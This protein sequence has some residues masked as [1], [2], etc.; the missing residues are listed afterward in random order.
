MRPP[1]ALLSS[2]TVLLG[3]QFAGACNLDNVGDPP[4]DADI[5]FPTGLFLSGQSEDSAA[6]FLYVLNSNFDLRYNRGSVQVFD[7][8]ALDARLGECASP[9]LNCQVP[10]TDLVVDEVLV[11][12]LGTA[13]SVSP[14]RRRLYLTSRTDQSLLYIDLDEN[15]DGEAVLQ[16]DESERRCSDDRR[17][18]ADT[19]ENARGALFPAEP[20]S[21]VTFP[22]ATAAPSLDAEN[23]PGDF[24]LVAHRW[25]QVSLFHDSGTGG[26]KLLQVLAQLPL[27]PTGIEFDPGTHLAYMSLYARTA[28]NGSS[29]LLSRLALNVEV[30][31]SG[32]LDASYL[33]DVGT[34]VIDGVAPQR[35]TRALRMN[36]ARQGQLL[37]T[38]ERPASL[39]FVNVGTSDDPGALAAPTLAAQEIVTVG[40]GPMRMAYG[41]I[42]DREIIAVSCFDAKQL[43][44][45]DAV[46]STVVSVIHNLNGPFD[47]GID[48]TRRRLYLSDFRASNVLVV[49]LSPLANVGMGERTDTPIIG[50]LGIP[51]VVMELQ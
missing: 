16:C 31:P 51:K 36:P 34:V 25:G 43:Y 37:V 7:L 45:V 5:Y 8:D 48:S 9:G 13:Y 22:A 44:L 10:A 24:V 12:S 27:E 19:A 41:K 15:A 23:T 1:C 18:G 30:S 46:R 47:V 35:S 28:A 40:D 6:R 17:R 26:P 2:L 21:I 3:L 42:G 20:V 14:D 49:D 29:R 39:L 38:G 4:P 50:T 32:S 33:Y 11:P